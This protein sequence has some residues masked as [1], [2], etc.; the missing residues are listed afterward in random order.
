MIYNFW[1]KKTF[2]S[3]NY[4][5]FS[6]K[7]NKILDLIVDKQQQIERRKFKLHSS[8]VFFLQFENLLSGK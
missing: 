4:V 3:S 2:I 7:I 8:K 5:G 6:L 1:V